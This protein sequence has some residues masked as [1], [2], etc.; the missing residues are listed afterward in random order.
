M[1]S[2]TG[3]L[4][5]QIFLYFTRMFCCS[6]ILLEYYVVRV[7]LESQNTKSTKHSF[8]SAAFYVFF[9]EKLGPILSFFD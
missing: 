7:V 8:V 3:Q 2:A 9:V 5:I 4:S 6:T 1:K